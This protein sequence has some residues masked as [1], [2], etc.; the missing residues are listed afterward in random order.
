MP[1]IEDIASYMPV[2]EE[3]VSQKERQFALRLGRA[4]GAVAKERFREFMRVLAIPGK[5]ASGEMKLEELSSQDLMTVAGMGIV[6]GA[7]GGLPKGAVG[8]G[9]TRKGAIRQMALS[10]KDV[11]GFSRVGKKQITKTAKEAMRNIP[12]EE[13]APLRGIEFKPGLRRG[14]GSDAEIHLLTKTVSL[15]PELAR[16]ERLRKTIFHEMAHLRQISPPSKKPLEVARGKF[17]EDVSRG[18]SYMAKPVEAQAREFALVL[19]GFKPRMST[20]GM[21]GRVFEATQKE[22]LRG[23]K[24]S[25]P[26]SFE[27]LLKLSRQW[28]SLSSDR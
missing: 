3:A 12:K 8:A 21:Y 22:A 1:R 27:T 11:P 16:P 2:G 23:I 20:K 7:P 15:E 9:M 5:I 19:G 10:A 26:E 6:G 25:Y 4:I 13:F 18:M 28:T 17:I 24:K 14:T